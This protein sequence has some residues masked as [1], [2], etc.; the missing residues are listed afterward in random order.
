[1][2][3]LVKKE[4]NLKNRFRKA[5]SLLVTCASCTNSQ[6]NTSSKDITRTC[7]HPKR[8]R[9]IKL[10][11]PIGM[12]LGRWDESGNSV[13]DAYNPEPL[14]DDFELGNQE[15][16]ILQSQHGEVIH[17]NAKC[18][19]VIEE[20]RA[21]IGLKEKPKMIDVGKGAYQKKDV[22]GWKNIFPFYPCEMPNC[23]NGKLLDAGRVN[24][25][26]VELI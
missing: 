24:S 7:A 5:R 15:A 1:M 21:R 19:Y 26:Q 25:Y 8:F 9:S 16:V 4:F 23:C 10:S 20:L 18:P 17:G 3:K 13:C 11:T 14:D 2:T 6:Q 22:S 12:G